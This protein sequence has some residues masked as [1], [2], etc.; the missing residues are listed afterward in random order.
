ML[1]LD[2]NKHRMHTSSPVY[3]RMYITV[4]ILKCLFLEDVPEATTVV[5]ALDYKAILA[6]R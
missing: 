4:S 5:R 1:A 2:G 6:L 3:R